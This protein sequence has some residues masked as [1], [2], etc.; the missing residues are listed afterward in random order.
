M[1]RIP[2]W[3]LVAVI[4][5]MAAAT[6][7]QPIFYPSRGQSAEKQAQDEAACQTWATQKTG[8]NPNAPAAPPPRQ[9][10]GRVRGAAAGATAAAVTGND[11]G[12]GAAVGAVA[13]GAAQRGARRQDARQASA[14]QQQ[15]AATHARA[16]GACMEG[17]GY[18]V[19]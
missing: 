17:R 2:I 16:V 10:G 14:Q 1:R 9:A 4:I 7:Q 13:G 12:K 8:V 18:A 6:A 15:A 19:R 3:T 11:A 5:P